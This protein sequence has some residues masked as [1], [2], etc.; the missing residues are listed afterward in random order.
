MRPVVEYL[1]SKFKSVYIPEEQL[2]L[3]KGRL[4]FKQYIP[5]KRARF[6]IKMFSLCETTGYLWNS[7]V[8]LGKEPDAAAGDQQLI[9][10]LG[11]SGAV[12]PRQMEGPLG[13]GYKLFVDNW[14]T[15]EELFSYL[16]D[17][18]TAAC[19]TARKNRLKLP[20]SLKTPPLAIGEHAFRRKDDML[21]VR[22]NDKKE[23]YFLSTMHKANVVDTGKRDRHGNNVRKLQLVNDYNKYMG[24]WIAMTS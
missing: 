6:G 22:L 19:G 14:Y 9:H 1:V 2:L 21:A 7:Y 3:W 4:V 24:V 16:Y 18:D 20:A 12:I 15:S 8:Y 17:N 11:K 13:K 10:R 23:I 5:L